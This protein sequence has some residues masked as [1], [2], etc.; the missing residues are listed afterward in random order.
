MSQHERNMQLASGEQEN[1]PVAATISL[2]ARRPLAKLSYPLIDQE[3]G[4]GRT[5]NFRLDDLGYNSAFGS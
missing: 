3:H 4:R 1:L 5:S 2:S